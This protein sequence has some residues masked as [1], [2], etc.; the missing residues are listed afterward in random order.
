[1]TVHARSDDTVTAAAYARFAN[2][3]KDLLLW[4]IETGYIPHDG[5]AGGSHLLSRSRTITDHQL[6][7]TARFA[8]EEAVESFAAIAMKMQGI[9]AHVIDESAE[10]LDHGLAVVG[11]PGTHMQSM[12]RTSHGKWPFDQLR[13]DLSIAWMS[14]SVL[15]GIWHAMMSWNVSSAAAVSTPSGNGGARRGTLEAANRIRTDVRVAGTGSQRHVIVS[16]TTTFLAATSTIESWAARME[17]YA[18][19]TGL[20]FE[21][22]DP[23]CLDIQPSASLADLTRAHAQ[24]MELLRKRRNYDY[25]VADLFSRELLGQ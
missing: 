17:V 12:E 13:G 2:L 3:D 10:I 18:D 6:V 7:M 5:K 8:Y 25:E 15:Q 21:T 14:L 11:E 20:E 19:G 4:L 16:V 1:M 24:A 22:D 9:L 23:V